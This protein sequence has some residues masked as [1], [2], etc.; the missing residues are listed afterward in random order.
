MRSL[1]MPMKLRNERIHFVSVFELDI[2]IMLPFSQK[3]NIH[4]IAMH[5]DQQ[6]CL[7]ACIAHQ[8]EK[9]YLG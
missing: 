2:S 8:G 7:S 6:A 4:N 3:G 1:H 9:L 5:T